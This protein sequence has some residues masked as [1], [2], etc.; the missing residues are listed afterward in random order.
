MC[1]P[2]S[3]LRLAEKLGVVLKPH[4]GFGRIFSQIKKN[5]FFPKNLSQAYCGG[6]SLLLSTHT[7]PRDVTAEKHRLLSERKTTPPSRP[8]ANGYSTLG[9]AIIIG[10]SRAALEL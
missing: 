4:L 9:L 3:D 8:K 5:G 1:L 10:P 6:G 2:T 7:G